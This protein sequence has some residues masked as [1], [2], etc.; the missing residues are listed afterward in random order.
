MTQDDL[1]KAA[2]KVG[3]SKKHESTFLFSDPYFICVSLTLILV[4][5]QARVHRMITFVDRLLSPLIS[6]LRARHGDIC[7]ECRVNCVTVDVE[8]RIN[9]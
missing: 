9:E 5:R 6:L 4:N 8:Y 7:S 2:R 3:E 1:N